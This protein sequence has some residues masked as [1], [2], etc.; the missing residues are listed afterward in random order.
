MVRGFRPFVSMMI[1]TAALTGTACHKTYDFERE[2]TPTLTLGHELFVIWKKDAERSPEN[3]AAKAQMLDQN[4]VGFVDAV[5]AIAPQAELRAIDTFLQNLLKLVDEGILP[6][7][8]RKIRVVLQEA[9]ADTALLTA[10]V[11]PSGPDLDTYV[12]PAQKPNLLG[13]VTAYPRLPELLKFVADVGLR[14]DGYTV[15]GA[16]TFDE[17]PAVTD[18]TRVGV[19]LLREATPTDEEPLAVMFRDMAMVENADYV[20]DEDITPLYV[21]LY[22]SRGYPLATNDDNGP[23]YP[24][25]DANQDGLADVNEKGEFIYANGGSGKLE[26][27]GFGTTVDEPVTR[28]VYGRA[29]LP[30]NQFAFQYVDLHS[31]GLGFLIREFRGLSNDNTLSD[32]LS[33][34]KAVL[35]PKNVFTDESGAYEGYTANQPLM[36]LSHAAVHMMDTP[37]MPDVMEDLAAVTERHPNA[38][39]GLAYAV[40]EMIGILGEFP[41]AEM[42]DNQTMMYDLLPYL[43]ELTADPE[44]FADVMD[45]MRSPIN[46]RTGDALATLI[47][48]SDSH[49]VPAAGG[50]YDACFMD[51]RDNYPIGTDARF[52]C[53]RSCPNGELFS[54]PN[55]F[56]APETEDGR[57][58]LQKF[59]HLIRDAN[60]TR[61]SMD[62]Q[63]ASFEG[64]PLPALP[65]LL[66]LP[67]AGEAFMASIAGNLDLA[68]YVPDS[69][70][71]SDVG[72]LLDYLGV[73]S[74]NVA[75]LLS[76]LSPLFGAELGR[77]PTPDQITRLFNQQ[78][79]RWQTD[80][81]VLDIADP[82]CKDGYVMSHHLA[83]GLYV[84]EASGMIDTI[85][86]LAKAFSDHQREDL[87]GDIL[88]VIH[89][90][91][92]SNASL[93]KT[94]SG[95]PSEM[96]A[97]NMRSYEQALE[98]VFANG[99]LFR[100]LN[101]FAVAVHDTELATGRP[102]RENLRVFLQHTLKQDGFMNYRG[103]DF[104]VMEDTRTL[105]N[106][107][108]MAFM[109]AA[110]GEGQKRLD[111]VPESRQRLRSSIGNVMDVMVGAEKDSN[112]QARF[113]RTGS[114][115][116][117]V[118]MM[119]YMAD[120]A[121]ER[122]ARGDFSTW[123]SSQLVPDLAELWTSRALASF[124]DLADDAL[125]TDADK[126]LIDD[127]VNYA[128]GTHEGRKNMLL[129]V[130]GLM[131][132]S[133][134]D[135]LWLPV[136]Q[137]LASAIDPDRVWDTEPYTQ[138][139]V[140]TL[141]AMLLAGTLEHDPTN[142]GIFMIHRALNRPSGGGDTPFEVVLEIIAAYFS[143]DPLSATLET[144]EDYRAFLMSFE[145]YMGD[146]LHGVERL[147]DL[148]SKRRK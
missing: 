133:V 122:I 47:R 148:V 137:F 29:T 92:A 17:N 60:G 15:N 85:Y 119:R 46:R 63:E 129:A 98:Q 70:W 80:K 33:A 136:G 107:S 128:F 96:K 50:A 123:I 82:V 3:A 126:A 100:A 140:V 144:P 2:D 130:H 37:V 62:I 131:A 75:A 114:P 84:G 21:V 51:C 117:A 94:K 86:P 135:D 69:L 79:M 4:Y 118:H 143:P 67:G 8:T 139:P 142:T 68:D 39:A 19:R 66:V 61:Y 74:G 43:Q 55:N 7:L 56:G 14:N 18:L 103:D 48:Y 42:T 12:D 10:L 36:E 124:V 22:D 72:E 132:R 77:V 120:E 38:I 1:V 116:L 76:T 112:G 89:D 5:D 115:A 101:D 145:E 59:L 45:A 40:D 34:F 23:A 53:I 81:I 134:N 91:Y 127:F 20:A 64:S 28:D 35:G 24:F 138:V 16:P 26:P 58:L 104:I 65:P 73:D 32:M 88:G 141:G 97:A 71:Q 99:E 52:T 27:F 6:A 49:T 78:D 113:V 30:N 57:S 108:R 25:V 93:Y 54:K 106:P 31:T 44:L 105:A 95:S 109:L 13:Y 147:Y 90:H 87:L 111:L 41:Q 102:I 121:R 9:A 110:L 125:K 146:D 11:Q 83:Y